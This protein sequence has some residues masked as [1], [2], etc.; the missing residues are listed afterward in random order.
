[1]PQEKNGMKARIDADTW[2][3]DNL[4]YVVEKFAGGYVVIVKG[5]G[6]VFTDADGTPRQIVKKA[7]SKY[8]GSIPL[9]FRVPHPQD[10]ICALTAP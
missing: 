5:K 8:P 1:L 4:E 3:K 7:K 10:F 9:F 2:L 6:I